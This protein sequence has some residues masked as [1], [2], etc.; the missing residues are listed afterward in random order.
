MS[1]VQA[2]VL[3]SSS[4][5]KAPSWWRQHLGGCRGGRCLPPPD[6]AEA[7]SPGSSNGS[8]EMQVRSPGTLTLDADDSMVEI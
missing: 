2:L 6:A 4:S 7:G 1:E 8:S 5:E 3:P